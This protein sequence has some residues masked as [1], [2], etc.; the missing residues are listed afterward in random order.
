M[1]ISGDVLNW[2]CY[3]E[4]GS[5]HSFDD[6]IRLVG[7]AHNIWR[8][9][10]SL[11]YPGCSEFSRVDAITGLKRAVNQRIKT[12]A[13]AYCFD[14]LPFANQRKT[15]EKFQFYG[16]IRP[17]LLKEIFEIRNAIEHMDSAPPDVNQCSRYIDFVWY[18]LKSTDS[19]L[20]MKKEDVIFWADTE[21][22]SLRFCPRFD[23]SWSI[24]V[25]GEIL[26]Q[27][28]LE[29]PHP[30]SLEIDEYYPRPHYIE[31]PIYGQWKPTSDQLRDFARIYFGLSR[32]WWK[33]HT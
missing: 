11:I 1:F 21:H 15:L 22:R 24:M 28:I 6:E 13:R 8:H 23:D 9:A 33:D 3:S 16:I 17:A 31:T 5:G 30:G 18:F 26:E 25:S 32:Y 7:R 19:L 10:S 12:L 20:E 14:G 27:D 4:N 2:T 29:C